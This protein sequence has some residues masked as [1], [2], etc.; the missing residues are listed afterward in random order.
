VTDEQPRFAA[1]AEALFTGEKGDK[2]DAG[3]TGAKGARGARGEK[4]LPVRQRRAIVF[5]FILAV[6]LA[7]AC[8]AG[9]VHYA[10]NLSAEQRAVASQQRTLAG[11]QKAVAREQQELRQAGQA[12]RR[13]GKL[14][15]DKICTT[16]GRLAALTP[17][18]GN[19]A[20]NPSRAYEDKLHAT[21]D[22]LGPDLRCS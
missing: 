1:G 9:L 8:L 6:L 19:P 7:A 12:S 3:P 13:Q 14:I 21:L 16:M 18:P 10:G 11:Q 20:A 2:G 5:L 4:G 17:P 15:E 22:Q